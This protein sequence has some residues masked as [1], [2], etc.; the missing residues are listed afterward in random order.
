MAVTAV[1]NR[2]GLNINAQLLSD[3]QV[4]NFASGGASTYLIMN[5]VGLAQR[6]YEKTGAIVISR[7]DYPDDRSD[8]PLNMASEWQKRAQQAPD[9]YHYWPNEPY[10]ND[11]PKQHLD[12][13]AQF[14]EQLG[15]AGVKACIGNFA[16]ASAINPGPID[17]GA[18]DNFLRIA[19]QWTNGGHGFVGMHEYMTGALPWG[20]ANKDQLVSDLASGNPLP[21]P[22]HW[23]DFAE[24]YSDIHTDYHLFRYL[25]LAPRCEQLGIEFPRVVMTEFGWDRME[26]LEASILPQLDAWR[27]GKPDDDDG[28]LSQ[29]N[30][31]YYKDTSQPSLFTRWWP[32]WTPE[33]AA[34]EQLAWCERTY[35]PHVVGLCLFA[36]NKSAQWVNYDY[37][38][39]PEVLNALP[40]I[41]GGD[42]E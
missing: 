16:A 11:T 4:L 17:A 36:V 12:E 9:V 40:S 26:D 41:P 33:Q 20:G 19:S 23:P 2:L 39:W 37:A 38:A 25:M 32:Q 3:D 24:L 42:N 29:G 35:S 10:I 22:D 18:W 34:I 7:G 31:D 27:G 5:N 1:A 28:L 8:V 6:V 21:G 14:M 15:D 13:Y 30:P